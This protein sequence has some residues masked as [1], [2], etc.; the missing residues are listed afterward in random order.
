M[1]LLYLGVALFALPHFFSSLLPGMRDRLSARFGAMR[2]KGVYAVISWIGF[3]LMAWAYFQTRGSGEMLF[4]PKG[5]MKHATM[6]LATLG[7]ILIG[8]SHGKSHIK[9]WLKNP[10]SLGIALWSVGHLL[11]V[12]VYAADWFWLCM[13]AVALVDIAASTLRGKS[14]HFQPQWSS[15]V[16][17]V[18]AGLVLTA[19]LVFLF[20]PFI[21][22][23]KVIGS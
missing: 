10:M 15:D 1:T 7:M 14:P 8:A 20:H 6:G 9:L 18:V 17:A 23:V 16:K 2:Y 5:G 22:G 12:G 4:T 11:S 3:G 21:L 13:L 19:L